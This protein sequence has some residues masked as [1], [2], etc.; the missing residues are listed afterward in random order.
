MNLSEFLSGIDLKQIVTSGGVSLL[1]LMTLI[2]ISPIKVNPWSWLAKKIGKALNSEIIEKVDNLEKEVQEVK[3]EA[4]E[5]RAETKE[6]GIISCRI[7]ILRFGDEVTHEVKHSKDHFDQIMSDIDQYERYC[8]EHPTF[9]NG[10]TV[11][12]ITRIKQTYQRRCEKN[13]FL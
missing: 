11:S 10:I 1:F 13:D 12:T 6:Q 4:R 8:R 2:Q 5:G 7:R 9:P 3:K